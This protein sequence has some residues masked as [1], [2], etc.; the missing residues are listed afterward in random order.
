MNG[1]MDLLFWHWWILGSG[2]IIL[3]L[4]APGTFFLWL[5]ISAFLVG[6][7]A[8]LL[9][10][11]AWQ[12][13]VVLFAVLTVASVVLWRKH[14][15]KSPI[16]TDRPFL[17]RRGAQLVGRTFTLVEPIINGRGKV[18]VGDSFWRVEGED[19][20]ADRPVKVVSVA[21]VLLKVELLNS[22]S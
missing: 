9:P 4:F 11:M 10:F 7:L 1:E 5:G 15:L 14:L 16:E 17:N 18:K 19:S 3:E 12:F 20:P 8:F 6:G 22:A 21:G 2:L 13:E